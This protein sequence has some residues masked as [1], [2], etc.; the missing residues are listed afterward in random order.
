MPSIDPSCKLF[1]DKLVINGCR[2]VL[3]YSCKEPTIL[4]KRHQT[5]QATNVTIGSRVPQNTPPAAKPTPTTTPQ[6]PL[7]KPNYNSIRKDGHSRNTTFRILFHSRLSLGLRTS[8]HTP[9]TTKSQ[10]WPRR[11]SIK[12]DY[13]D[14]E[15]CYRRQTI[16]W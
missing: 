8:A 14:A 11:R 10:S 4:S 16:R 3:L 1:F 15:R 7:L 9:R 13:P 6:P 12:E 2:C 5:P